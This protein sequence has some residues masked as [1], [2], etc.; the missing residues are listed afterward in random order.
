MGKKSKRLALLALV[1]LF[2]VFV[3][4]AF[5]FELKDMMFEDIKLPFDVDYTRA[6][7][8]WRVWL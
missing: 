5:Y 7:A 4:L 8:F 3:A 1:L 6:A 2:I